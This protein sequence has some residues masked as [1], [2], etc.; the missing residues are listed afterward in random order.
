M[1]FENPEIEKDTLSLLL[2]GPSYLDSVEISPL[3]FAQKEYHY[4]FEIIQRYYNKFHESISLNLFE[5]VA[6]REKDSPEEIIV[7]FVE[8]EANSP[9]GSFVSYR[10]TL[11]DLYLKR[12]VR[13]TVE[14]AVG[15]LEKGGK[16]AVETLEGSLRE[17]RSSVSFLGS[18]KRRTIAEGARE[19]KAL[20]LDKKNHPEDYYGIPTGFIKIDKVTKLLPTFVSLVFGRTSVGK[21]R[22]LFN[23]GYNASMRGVNVMYCSLEMEISLLESLWDSRS[24]F[25]S[26]FHILEGTLNEDEEERYL[27]GLKKTYQEKPPFY[28]VDIVEGATPAML[29]GELELYRSKFG[30]YPELILVDYG[31]LMSPNGR[32]FTRDEKYGLLYQEFRGIARKYHTHIFSASQRT[33]KSLEKG[34]QEDLQATQAVSLSDQIPQA[35]DIVFKLYEGDPREQI[36]GILFLKVVKNRWGPVG[37]VIELFAD[38]D[39]S[40]MSDRFIDEE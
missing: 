30:F 27:R 1:I 36:E 17:I 23:L 24:Q 8:I 39:N 20:Y 3:F 40:Y 5:E 10:D 33:R 19:R 26:L 31:T 29:E 34:S 22:F 14:K 37:K 32:Y 2:K 13:D 7:T 15:S 21:S 18:I 28:T 4:I 35:C 38:F 25:V 16:M 9:I 12:R 11:E 6:R